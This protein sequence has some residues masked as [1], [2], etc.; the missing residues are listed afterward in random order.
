MTI[1]RLLTLAAT[2]AMRTSAIAATQTPADRPAPPGVTTRTPSTSGTAL[3][4]GYVIGA[5]DVLSVIFWREKDMTTD[6]VVR[7]DG[8]ISLPVLNDVRAAGL[9]P[10]Q[11]ASNVETAAAKYIN[12][13]EVTVIVK[14][15][16]SR[17]V[18][19]VGEVG[20]PGSFPLASD[21][22]VLQILAEAGG[23]LETAKRSGIVV[24]REENGRTRR[25]AFNYNDVLKGKKPE[26]NI[27][28]QPGDTI[29]VR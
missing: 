10:E 20:K 3:P 21:T 5:E 26:Q 1:L 13:A 19:V 27:R 4:T 25:F 7:P 23:L 2:V 16:H 22:T 11:L 24:L 12:G 9:T 28:L 8:K 18:F 17:K 15:I 14:E 29:L 6:V